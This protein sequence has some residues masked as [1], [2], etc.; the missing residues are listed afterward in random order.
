MGTNKWDQDP[1]IKHVYTWQKFK[2]A[3]I[4]QLIEV[5]KA[6]ENCF[7]LSKSFII[8]RIS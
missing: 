1:E 7:N 4:E 6:C 3:S 5:E 8:L 2:E